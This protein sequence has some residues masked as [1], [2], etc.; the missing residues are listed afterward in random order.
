MSKQVV[1]RTQA[2]A[3]K[4]THG[5]DEGSSSLA[6]KRRP[7]GS[8]G[9]GERHQNE[10]HG[11]RLMLAFEALDA[12]PALSESRTRLLSVIS[13]DNVATADIVST[14]ESDV[15]LIIAVMRLAN[16]VQ[17][18]GER[19]ETVVAAVDR[20]TPQAVQGL[21][22]RVRTFDFFERSNGWDTAP[23]RFRLHALATQ[24]AADRLAAEVGYEHRDRLTV[25]SLLHDV[26][27]LVLMHA[28][29]GYVV[30]V[31]KLGQTPEKRIQQERRELGVDHALV[32]GVLARRWGLPA[33]IA[34][35]IERHHNAEVTGEA[36]F[37]RLADM[38]AHYAHGAPVA[39]A[40]MLSCA[41]ALG[42][43]P[44][45]LR[46]VMYELPNT[47][48]RQRM[49][50]PCPLSARELGVL[51]RLAEGKVYKQIAH[52]LTL[53]TSTVRTHLHNIYGKLGAVDRAQAVLIATERGWL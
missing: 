14:V 30:E 16:D 39:P 4:P 21:A 35:V 44:E 34:T 3:T 31:Q 52:E 12:F 27:K 46:R 25:T 37:V 26:G 9:S 10:G 7:N 49:V 24:Q 29:P 6:V 51:Q 18:V 32:G 5:S 45:E 42:L 43:G 36:A 50:D 15:A 33:T 11:H 28:Y 13:K 17:G 40:E 23:E 19:V 20:L 22:S 47:Q 48:Q 8:P 53:S 41:R 1:M 38:L 2:T